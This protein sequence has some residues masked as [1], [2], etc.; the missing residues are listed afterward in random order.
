M[1]KLKKKSWYKKLIF[2]ISIYFCIPTLLFSTPINL[3]SYEFRKKLIPKQSIHSNENL[4]GKLLLDK[5]VYQNSFY[6]DIRIVSNGN[7]VPY[8]RQIKTKPL[9]KSGFVKPKLLFIK[10][11]KSGIT[12]L[13][14][15]P[16]I[17]EK[18]QMLYI[19][20]N[21][22]IPFETRAEIQMGNNPYTPE[23]IRKEFIFSYNSSTRN[24]LIPL[25]SN[26]YR[27][28]RLHFDSEIDLEFPELWYGVS[29]EE[30][31][32]EFSI[33]IPQPENLNTPSKTQYIFPNENH[34]PFRTI[35]LQM[36]EKAFRRKFNL[37]SYD[38]IQGFVDIA[39]GYLDSE[40]SKVTINL[41]DSIHTKWKLEIDNEDNPP[42][43]L[44]EVIVSHPIEE[45]IF[46]LP[47][48]NQDL[49]MYYGFQ[50]AKEPKYDYV[51]LEKN[52][53]KDFISFEL[54]NQELNPL[55]TYSP[56]YP[57]LSIW[58][59]RGLFFFGL[60]F[61][62]YFSYIALKNFSREATLE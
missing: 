27:Y 43:H 11:E 53:F 61:S 8:L 29:M 5:E 28:V 60:V 57:P 52:E 32:M 4:K 10:P 35:S 59:L 48:T 42:L 16:P 31:K 3:S 50:Y 49:F 14:E 41:T 2:G 47:N 12:Y 26:Y 45:L 22:K 33:S 7:E 19:K 1:R 20:A 44:E 58:I 23:Y 51:Y 56:F 25:N 24:L 34:I 13:I 46:I 9:G 17:P 55:K 21:S 40:N 37:Y 15:V 36:K 54:G 6:S 30:E 38:P 39:E 62:F 18:S